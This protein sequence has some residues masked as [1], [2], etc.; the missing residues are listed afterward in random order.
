MLNDGLGNLKNAASISLRDETWSR[1]PLPLSALSPSQERRRLRNE[2]SLA[3]V[4]K[5]VAI[6]GLTLAFSRP[7]ERPRISAQSMFQAEAPFGPPA[8]AEARP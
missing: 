6:V 3:I 1:Y 8:K 7:S 2:V 4:V 5:L